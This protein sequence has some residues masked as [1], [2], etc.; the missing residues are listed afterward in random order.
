MLKEITIINGTIDKTARVAKLLSVSDICKDYYSTK[1]I[2]Y[3]N[4]KHSIDFIIRSIFIT[5][6]KER[7]VIV[8]NVSR[9]TD[10]EKLL[11]EI[12]IGAVIITTT[13]PDFRIFKLKRKDISFELI[14][15]KDI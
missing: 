10:L 1:Y 4:N 15:I 11:T 2:T 7:Y 14:T 5:P 6:I 12:K 9:E 13:M 8:K 3:D